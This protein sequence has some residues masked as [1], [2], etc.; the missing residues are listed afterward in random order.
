MIASFFQ[1]LDDEGVDYLLISGQATI[2]Y[3]AAT[4]SE[5]VDLWVA[6]TEANLL[7]FK[8]LVEIKKTQRAQDY[9]II[10]RLA[11]AQL[12]DIQP[13]SSR[14]DLVWALEITFGLPELRSLLDRYPDARPLLADQPHP[15]PRWAAALE[16]G[17][18]PDDLQ[19]DVDVALDAK[20]AMLRR[21]DRR[22]WTGIIDELRE[23][24]RLG[25]LAE[26]GTPV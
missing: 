21:A 20:A 13:L 25:Q 14:E 4:F 26:E 12:D 6:P 15:F 7:R 1:R 8:D 5:D 9:P 10:S 16:A 11:R 22:Y 17:V 3:G 23:L 18:I 19:D 2:L 24:K